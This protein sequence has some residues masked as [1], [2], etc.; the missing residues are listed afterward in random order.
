M[1]NNEYQQMEQTFNQMK[2]QFNITPQAAVNTST[3]STST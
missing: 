1:E 3:T 2:N